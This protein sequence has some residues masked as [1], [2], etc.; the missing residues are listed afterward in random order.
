MFR[1]EYSKYYDIVDQGDHSIRV[2]LH[3][4]GKEYVF[5]QNPGLNKW[6][7]RLGQA[8][9]LPD[10]LRTMFTSLDVAAKAL[11]MYCC[12]LEEGDQKIQDSLRA[13]ASKEQKEEKHASA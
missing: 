3:K 13:K 5:V 2:K 9:N 7:V 12:R 8:G 10:A 4:G 11:Y 1:K 6:E